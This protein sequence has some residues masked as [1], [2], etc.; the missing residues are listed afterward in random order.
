MV[1]YFWFKIK[2]SWTSQATIGRANGSWLTYGSW[3]SVKGE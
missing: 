3:L 2:G 1:H